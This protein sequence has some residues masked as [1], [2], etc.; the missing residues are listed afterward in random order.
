MLSSRH[1]SRAKEWLRV[2]SHLS[3]RSFSALPHAAH[4]YDVE[5]QVYVEGRAISRAAVLNRPSPLNALDTY[6][7]SR[8]R[9][10]Y[11]SWEENSHV[12]FVMMKGS[13]KAF[14]SGAD[15]ISLYQLMNDGK[16]EECK[17][18]FDNLYR[19]VYL[20]GT[21]MKPH[22]AILDGMTM[23]A[24]AGISLPGMFRV[25]TDR[26]VF[27]HPETQLGFHPDAGASFYLSRLP[28]YLVT[29]KVAT[30]EYLALTGEKLNGEEMIACGLATH[31]VLNARLPMVEARLGK[32]MT[33]D[34]SVIES[35]LA[36]YGDLVYPDKSSLLHRIETIDKCFVHDTV[37]EIVDA[38]EKEA[39]ETKDVWCSS[40]LKKLREASPLSL[41]VSLESIRG[42][43]YHS[44][45]KC[46]SR[47]YRIS[48]NWVSKTVSNDFSE[49]IRARLVD[50]DFAPT[51][52]PPTLGD[53]TKDMVDHYF[54]PLSETE[55]ELE[56]PVALRE[57]FM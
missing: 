13:G 51:W 31:Y 4:T 2:T 25:V 46:L 15:A 44:L 21:Y 50:K 17:A 8:I 27:S 42:G 20:V 14:C 54:S 57:P 56:L 12:G 1:L 49:G 48:H 41:K 29:L 37:E 34:S 35:S 5:D 24:G 38:L 30:G 36:H 3:G 10:L 6:M 9:R 55:P 47:E 22:V 52:D 18:F 43:R 16:V 19:F 28:G 7:V 39:S 53:V 26:T 40:A 33:D 32:L 23:G 45:D 11:E